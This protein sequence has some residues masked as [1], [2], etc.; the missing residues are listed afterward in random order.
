MNRSNAHDFQ[1]LRTRIAATALVI[2]LAQS[3][4]AQAPKASD[5]MP[6][7]KVSTPPLTIE[8]LGWLEGC[9]RGTV[10]QREFREYW[11]PLR[12]GMIVGAG[13][14][15][16]QDKTQDFEYMRIETRPDG[17]YYIVAPSGKP[18]AS[19]K[20]A[21]ITDD[22]N[23]TEFTF[24]KGADEFPQRVVYHRGAE[25]WLYASIEGK[26]NGEERKVIYPMRRIGCESGEL[27]FK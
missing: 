12:G 6:D 8:S 15:V 2:M 20:L 17:V 11:L 9:W 18:E 24:A 19:F 22:G 1:V 16:M 4:F 23:G 13:H 10:N 14:T 5:A 27:I 21:M 7:A 25:G 3:A 26:A